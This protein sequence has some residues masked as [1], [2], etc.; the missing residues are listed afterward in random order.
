MKKIRDVNIF[1]QIVRRVP[2]I[3]AVY[4]LKNGKFLYINDSIEKILGYKSKM[5]LDGGLAFVN[6]LI[7]P[8]DLKRVLEANIIGKRKFDLLKNTKAGDDITVNVE[9]RMKHRSGTWRWIRTEGVIFSKDNKGDIENVMN[10]SVDITSLKKAELKE[11]A[12]RK[13][14]EEAL[15]ASEKKFRTLIQESSD[16]IQLIDASGKILYSSD[17]VEKVFGYKPEEIQGE[18]PTPFIHPDD[19]GMFLEKFTKIL[20]K[21]GNQ[22]SHEYRVRHKNGNWIWIEATA[23]NR[24]DDPNIKAVVGNFRNITQRKMLEKQKD[25]FLGIVS[26]E[27]KTPVTSIKAFTQVMQNR[28]IKARDK[29][30]AALLSKMDE[31][32]NKLT[33]LIQDLL[34]ISRV[35]SGKF[36]LHKGYFDFGKLI[37]DVIYLMQMTTEKHQ[38]ILE[39]KTSPE[40]W[41]DKERIEQVI[42]NLLTNAIK[43]SPEKSKIIVRIAMYDKSVTTCIEDSGIGIPEEHMKD[44]FSRFFRIEEN[45]Y[46]TVPGMGLGLNIASEIIRLHGGQIWA[47]SEYKKGSRFYFTIPIGIDNP[48]KKI[49]NKKNRKK[50]AKKNK[51]AIIDDDKSIVEV[52][53]LI[54][55]DEG[56]EVISATDSETYYKLMKANPDLLLLDIW[57]PGKNGEEICKDLKAKATTKHIPIILVSANQSTERVARKA[58]AD[59]FI[60]KPFEME[61]LLAKVAKYART[62]QQV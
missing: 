27:L 44:I 37:Q 58:G 61:D 42:I 5:F 38:I 18:G 59:D 41:A 55:E 32:I 11:A 9:Y 34:D 7:H 60:T 14:F 51:I 21:P 12:A 35:D 40:I 50:H 56:Y 1:E 30:S 57:M 48:D 39:S 25:E 8:D 10:I 17:S 46:N 62:M 43:Y 3:V 29:T 54:L 16:A 22:A 26:H 31:Q 52:I 13:V 53:T 6:S 19:I 15:K 28:F 20:E 49:N 23:V 47:E 24:L 2:G 33:S 45:I 36:T 4:K